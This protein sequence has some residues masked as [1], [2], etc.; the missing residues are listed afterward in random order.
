MTS[1]GNS[2]L[3]PPGRVQG[4]VRWR[5]FALMFVPA[6]GVAGALVGL[7]ASGALASSISVSGTPFTV[8]ANQLDGSGFAQYGAGLTPAGHTATPV[9]VSVIHSGTLSNLCQSVSVGP[10]SLLLRAGTGATPVSASNLVVA[11]DHLSGDATFK[12]IVIGQNAGTLNVPSGTYP[13]PTSGGF[14][15]SASHVTINNLVQHTWL[16][17]AGTFTLPGLS[18]GFTTAS[19]P[20]P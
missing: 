16:T 8:T 17:T 4:R 19:S 2:P 12:N 15:E 5:R 13:P 1:S 10:V 18:L 3:E 9:A 20:C 7:T 11:A 14:G 6:L